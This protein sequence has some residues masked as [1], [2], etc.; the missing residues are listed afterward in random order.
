MKKIFFISNGDN[1]AYVAADDMNA[2]LYLL[3]DEK[4]GVPSMELSLTKEVEATEGEEAQSEDQALEISLVDVLAIEKAATEEPVMVY[5]KQLS[6]GKII[7][8]PV[9]EVED[10]QNSIAAE[11]QE[12]NRVYYYT[13]SAYLI[14]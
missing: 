2:A 4:K 8:F 6:N 14:K 9:K 3:K 5:A 12:I 11:Q 13:D 7:L 10:I 1:R